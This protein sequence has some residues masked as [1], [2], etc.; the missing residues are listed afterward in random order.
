MGFYFKAWIGLAKY[1]AAVK[2]K[3]GFVYYEGL[4]TKY[5]QTGSVNDM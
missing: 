4:I 1:R 5:V 2:F 3:R